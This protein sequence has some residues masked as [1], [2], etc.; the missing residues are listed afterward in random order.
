LSFFELARRQ[1]LKCNCFAMEVLE[2]LDFRRGIALAA[3]RLSEAARNF[4]QAIDRKSDNGR[5]LAGGVN[6]VEVSQFERL[7]GLS[8]KTG[9]TSSEIV[10]QALAEYLDRRRIANAAE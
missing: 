8:T 3:D 1:P 10:R 9:K 5:L 4:A 2:F 7:A 6:P